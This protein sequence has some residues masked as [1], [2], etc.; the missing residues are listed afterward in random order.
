MVAYQIGANRR[1]RPPSRGG[2]GLGH[3][4]AHGALSNVAMADR[5]EG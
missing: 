4:K 1:R 2:R 3:V 5:E